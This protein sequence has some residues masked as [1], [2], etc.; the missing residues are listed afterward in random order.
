MPVDP[1]PTPQG[2]DTGLER[3]VFFSDAV[4]AIAITLLVLDIRLPDSIA[5]LSDRELLNRLLA[6]GPRYFAYVISFLVIGGFWIGHHRRFRSILFYNRWLIF[7][8]L[9]LMMVVA[10][11]PFP[12]GVI[13]ENGNRTG[14]IF[15]ALSITL[16]GLLSAAGWIYACRAG[17][18]DPRM[19]TRETNSET[20]QSLIVPGVF[21]TSIALAF[22]DPD[23]AKYAWLLTIPV[24]FLIRSY[25]MRTLEI[26]G[27]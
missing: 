2:N 3:L 13:A 23:L 25:R 16:V 6:V 7:L 27:L 21:L 26:R 9:L 8:N 12:T 20:W 18:V 19:T 22:I 24:T 11:I 15:Y 5:G 4:F 1:P 10:F 17:L 14:T